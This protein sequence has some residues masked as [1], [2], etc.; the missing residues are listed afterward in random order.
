MSYDNN[1]RIEKAGSLGGT[2]TM[3]D[4]AIETKSSTPTNR[5]AGNYCHEEP[6]SKRAKG[7][8]VYHLT[9]GVVGLGKL[10]APMAAVFAK[11]GFNV[12]GCDLNSD[13]VDLVNAGR[14]PVEETNLQ[15]YLDAAEGT[16]EATSDLARVGRDA[17][18]IF[19]IVPTPSQADA[20]FTNE[21]VVSAIEALGTG[22]RTANAPRNVV[23]T[24]T[25]MPGATGGPIRDALET[26]AG[27]PLGEDLGLCYNPEFIALGSVIRDMEYPDFILIGESA[28]KWG[29]QLQDIY[30]E[31]CCNEPA[32]KR[33]N[34]VNAEI[35]KIAVNTYTTTKIS[36]ANMLA[37]LCGKLPGADVD[38]VSDAVGS[39]SRV[40]KK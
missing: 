32:F 16:V 8:N 15:A 9:L 23:V 31:S 36:Y 7:Q 6:V 34:F 33:M 25:V 24:S 13:M 26:A 11:H 22:I 19:I 1:E 30:S 21:Y 38:T 40:G 18:V 37:E 29:Q 35:T 28:P 10:G 2:A 27:K 3:N 4:S 12:I 39:D 17:D 5:S 20:T 14:A